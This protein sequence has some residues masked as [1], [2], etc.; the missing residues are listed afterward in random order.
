MPRSIQEVLDHADRLAQRF[1]QLDPA[2]GT[3]LDVP[4]YLLRRAVLAQ[5]RSERNV[6]EAVGAARRAGLSWSRIGK[7]LGVSAQAAQQRY[8]PAATAT[9]K[10]TTVR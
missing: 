3:D 1:E 7:E 10:S 5:A 9:S 8:G 4:E 6:V 2:D